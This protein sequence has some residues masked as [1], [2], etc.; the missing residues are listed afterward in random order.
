MGTNALANGSVDG[1]KLGNGA[2]TN[3]KLGPN[4]VTGAKIAGATITATNIAPGQVVKGNGNFVTARLVV[5]DA[6]IDT[7]AL[8]GVGQLRASCAAGVTTISFLNQSGAAAEAT[9]WG[10]TDATAVTQQTVAVANGGST[11]GIP[12]TGN[13]VLGL[14]YQVVSAANAQQ[15]TTADI[16]AGPAGTSCAVVA[17]GLT[18]G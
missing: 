3:D 17:S 5:A 11:P 15:V 16:S 14:T 10:A 7:R 18:T 4:A 9:A 6:A 12:A 1:A 2:V 13:N 8:P